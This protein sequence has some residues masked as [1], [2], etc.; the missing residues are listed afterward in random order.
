MTAKSAR[1]DPHPTERPFSIWTI[2]ISWRQSI[3]L[4][5][6]P[7]DDRNCRFAEAYFC[8][9]RPSV[10]I[11]VAANDAVITGNCLALALSIAG[12]KKGS[13]LEVLYWLSSLIQHCVA[14]NDNLEADA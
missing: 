6:E 8:S 4:L 10:R 13:S 1:A 14:A 2:G 11:R 12:T 5:K 3:W 7:A 9:V